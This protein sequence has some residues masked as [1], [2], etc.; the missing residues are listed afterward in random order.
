[1]ELLP[2]LLEVIDHRCPLG[3]DVAGF[4]VQRA[5]LA[6]LVVIVA[7]EIDFLVFAFLFGTLFGHKGEGSVCGSLVQDERVG[8]H[9]CEFVFDCVD[10]DKHVGLLS[11]R[12]LQA[13][14]A[15]GSA[16]I[17]VDFLRFLG[18]VGEHALVL[19]RIYSHTVSHNFTPLAHPLDQQVNDAAD[20]CHKSKDV[21]FAD[22]HFNFLTSFKI[23][24]SRLLM[25]RSSDRMKPFMLL[26]LS[27]Y[28]LSI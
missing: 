28:P 1:M 13:D 24:L 14:A 5:D 23:S 16:R 4:A 17:G 3:D 12:R 7:D 2:A 18:G 6:G 8:P 10:V 27:M 25:I 11:Y 19:L 20:G 9:I 26:F 21:I 22:V 15:P